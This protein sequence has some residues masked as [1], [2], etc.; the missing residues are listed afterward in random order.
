MTSRIYVATSGYGKSNAIK[1]LIELE[2]KNDKYK[3]Y[4][5][6]C[7]QESE[8]SD[9]DV[10]VLSDESQ[11]TQLLQE[12]SKIIVFN[13]GVFN[14]RNGDYNNAIMDLLDKAK[15]LGHLVIFEE[16]YLCYV[17]DK[18]YEKIKNLY[19]GT[20]DL[21]WYDLDSRIVTKYDLD[22]NVFKIGH[23]RKGEF[24]HFIL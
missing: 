16:C 4:V 5:W 1:S 8:N 17:P 2:L 9:I 13:Q 6:F 3:S 12:R 24:S 22:N 10:T 20:L 14:E 11:I 21:K 7:Y 18:V 15:E 19:I 23:Y